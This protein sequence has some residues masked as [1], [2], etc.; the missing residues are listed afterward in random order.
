MLTFPELI[1]NSEEA[2]KLVV[3]G[4]QEKY[5]P[6]ITDEKAPYGSYFSMRSTRNG[7]LTLNFNEDGEF[8]ASSDH[9]IGGI[10]GEVS[11][12]ALLS[13]L[14][15]ADMAARD[16]GAAVD[17][18]TYDNILDHLFFFGPAFDV[19]SECSVDFTEMTYNAI[20]C[21]GGPGMT[22]FFKHISELEAALIE[23]GKL[24][25]SLMATND[26]G[27]LVVPFNNDTVLAVETL[28]SHCRDVVPREPDNA[29][30]HCFS[31]LAEIS[32]TQRLPGSILKAIETDGAANTVH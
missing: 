15:E 6:V 18:D 23:S 30:S 22:M 13:S 8:S 1:R 12:P 17:Y 28:L 29:I 5:R 9:Q 7:N 14:Y 26:G 3:I 27:L 2:I 25:K 16:L 32:T 24:V 10:P 20:V 4:L 21:L 19:L 11:I 31:A